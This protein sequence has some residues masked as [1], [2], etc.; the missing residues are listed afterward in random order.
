MVSLLLFLVSNLASCYVVCPA[1]VAGL[2]AVPGW[3]N[4]SKEALYSPS[5]RGMW[6]LF[7]EVTDRVRL[8]RMGRMAGVCTQINGWALILL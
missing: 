3:L 8:A 6:R 4:S 7:L 2:P 1:L 5:S